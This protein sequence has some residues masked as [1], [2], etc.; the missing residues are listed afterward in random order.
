[1]LKEFAVKKNQ[2]QQMGYLREDSLLPRGE[3][4]SRIYVQEILVTELIFADIFGRLDD[5]QLNALLST[6][7]FEARKND[8]FQRSNIFDWSQ[9]REVI[10]YVQGNCGPDAAHYDPRVAVVTYA[11]SQGQP[12]EQVQRLANLDEGDIISVFRRTIDLLRQ[13]R[14]AVSDQALRSRFKTCM[15]KLD[16]DEAALVEI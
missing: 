13:M 6:V 8:V 9:V 15:E 12:F 7:D 16:R 2:L 5:D 10:D 14:D 4:A 3:A 1:L 11:W